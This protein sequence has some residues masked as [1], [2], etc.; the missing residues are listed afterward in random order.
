MKLNIKKE[1]SIIISCFLSILFL[2]PNLSFAS[3]QCL[4]DGYTIV[5]INGIN[6]TNDEARNNSVAL[7]QKFGFNFDNQKINYQYL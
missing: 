7:G 1:Y 4:K 2:F 6:T 3:N 5:T